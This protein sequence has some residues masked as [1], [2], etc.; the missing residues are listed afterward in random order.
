MSDLNDQQPI[1]STFSF[2]QE[3]EK[4]LAFW[5]TNQIFEKSLEQTKHAQSFVFYDGPPFA[6]GLPH[7]GHLLASTLKDVVPRYQTMLGKYVSRRFGWDC[8]GVPIEYEIDKQYG[9]PTHQVIEEFGLKTYTDACRG[10]VQKYSGEWRKTI[11]RLGRWVDFDNDY[12]TMDL[13]FMESVWWVFKTLWDKGLIYNG[14]KVVPFSTAL[15]TVL[16]NFEASS[17]YQDTQDPSVIILFPLDSEEAHLAIW[18]TTPWT[19]PSN[20]G[21]CVNANI[22]YCK[23]KD[24]EK[25]TIFYVAKDRLEAVTHK[26]NIS[27]LQECLGS[28]LVGKSYKPPFN[29]FEDCK[30]KGAFKVHADDFVTTSGGTGLVHMAPA[31]GEDD[32][33]VMQQAGF[34]ENICPVNDHGLFTDVVKDF[35]GMHVKK[36]ADKAIMKDLKERGLLYDQSTIVHSYPFCPRSDTPLIYRSIPSWYVNVETIKDRMMAANQKIR[37]VPEHIKDGRFGKWLEGARDWAISRNRVW[38]T[39]L[40]IWVNDQTGAMVCMGSVK[41]LQDLTHTVITDLH[42]DHADDLTFMKDGEAGV[43]RRIPEVLDCWFESGAMPYAQNHYPFENKELVEKTFPAQFI[44]EGVDQTR[45]WFYTLI[46]LSAA[47]FDKP[48]FE[49]VIVNGLVLAQDGKKMSKRLKNYT[50]AE[51]L[52]NHYGADA[53]RLFLINSGLVKAEEQRFSDEG[54]KD[55]I[56]RTLLPWYNAFKFFQTYADVDQWQVS[57]TPKKSDHI[58]DVWIIS[59]L[60]SLK[61]LIAEHMDAYELYHVVPE[62]LLF[63]EELTNTYIRLNRARFWESGMGC[64]KQA[65]FTTL[66]TVLNELSKIMAPFTPFLSETIY[67]ALKKYNS[68]EQ[69][70]SVH[71]CSYPKAD[72]AFID[73]GLESAVDR[74]TQILVLARQQRNDAKIKIKIPLNTMTVIHSDEKLLKDIQKLESIIKKEINVKTIEYSEQEDEYLNV[75]AKPNPP[76]VSKKLLINNRQKEYGKFNEAIR[77]L[78]KEDIYRFESEFVIKIDNIIFDKIDN[79][80]SYKGEFTVYK[81]SPI[82]YTPENGFYQSSDENDIIIRREPKPGSHVVTNGRISLKLDLTLSD[83]LIAEGLAREVISHIQKLRKTMDF[84]V[85]DRIT[86]HYLA[87]QTLEK[88]M[89]NFK[90]MICQETLATELIHQAAANLSSH[91]IDGHGLQLGL[92][93]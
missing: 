88:V 70:L 29:Y 58:L 28:D 16:S 21:V 7:Y 30:A 53:L 5:Q 87:D 22:T 85:A 80:M 91:D 60:Q 50:P 26:K 72:A 9:K 86:V 49:N 25:N 32:A 12:K 48:A 24:N 51:D 37:W 79:R 74:L 45:G 76:K 56:R 84:N 81:G 64:D 69:P 77:K 19:L 31:F 3:E 2:T 89:V 71:L 1:P 40:P 82:T 52:L 75:S 13:D 65:A 20:M 62:L 10:V 55:M 4:I 59:R 34:K 46:I 14:T 42:R 6:T 83:D 23:V 78:S 90:D 15:G 92:V 43:Y 33:R 61:A 18:T 41:E 17:N 73:E 68:Q 66:Y 11:G 57:H 8:H 39:P 63:I 93:K 67:L 38:G 35:A 54:V 27:I 36:E 44:A 47:L